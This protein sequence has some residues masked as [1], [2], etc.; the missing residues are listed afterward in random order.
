MSFKIRASLIGLPFFDL[1]IAMNDEELY[2][3]IHNLEGENRQLRQA[4]A[5][6]TRLAD[7]SG[8]VEVVHQGVSAAAGAEWWVF[9]EEYDQIFFFYLGIAL[10]LAG[11]YLANVYYPEV[12][13]AFAFV[14][15]LV[16]AAI[17]RWKWN[18]TRK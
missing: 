9:W 3:L 2:E 6:V 16:S 14:L 15:L 17:T 10:S 12:S 11:E 7:V 1:K 13:L 8:A 4:L 5:Q 18:R